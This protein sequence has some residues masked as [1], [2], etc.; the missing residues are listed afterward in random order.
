M[1]RVEQL[2]R[3]QRGTVEIVPD[4]GLAAKLERAAATGTP[5][6]VKLGLDPSAPD[7]HLGHA[8]PL[9][10]LRQFQDLGHEVHVIIGDF[11]AMIGDPSGRSETRRPLGPEEV[12][13]NARTYAE[14]YSK[15]LDPDRTH[16][17]F[18]SEWLGGLSFEQVVHLTSKYTVARL[19]ERDDFERR[20][21]E[22][23]PIAVHEFMYA[24][25]QAYDSV[26]LRADV[27]MGG[28]DQRFNILMGR[29][30]QREYGQEPQVAL[31]TPL[32]V[33]LDGQQKMSK[34]L[35][36]TVGVSEPPLEQ[37]RKLMSIADR[38]LPAYYEFVTELPLDAA[39]SLIADAPMEAKKQLAQHVVDDYHGDGAGQLARREWERIY[40]ARQPPA[41]ISDVA[42]PAA[43][44]R[45]DGTIWLPRLLV[46]AGLAGGSNE[47]RRAVEQKAVRVDGEQI[48]DP[49]AE[50]AFRDGMVIQIGR[51]RFAR[52]RG[53][54]DRSGSNDQDRR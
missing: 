8:I 35:G 47:A 7:L 18:N 19:L 14:Q 13:A 43:E 37:F 51:R 12:R 9:R 52:V 26:Q 5:L 29:D 39:R 49:A 21:R 24:F 32:L 50:L 34:S 25:C 38:L 2:D 3:L 54:G 27:E 53:G 48:T 36:N 30:I 44:I 20:F 45:P 6:R 31:F 46:L 22:G 15:L 1:T 42:V 23:H 41:E 10:K 40:S 33:G 17:H 4:G 28:T 16:V 11:T